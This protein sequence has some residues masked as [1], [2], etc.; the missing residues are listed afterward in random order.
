MSSGLS[1]I[2][3]FIGWKWP[4]VVALL[5]LILPSIRV[6]GPT[7]VGL[8]MKRFSFRKLSEDNP[9]AFNG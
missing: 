4:L 3:L 8:V 2:L 6:I 9:I 1:G 5:I 7:E